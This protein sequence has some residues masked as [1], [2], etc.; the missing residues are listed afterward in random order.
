MDVIAEGVESEAQFEQL[1]KLRCKS[2]QGSFFQE[3][4]TK[5]EMGE[6]LSRGD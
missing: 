4:R 6:I 5:D 2:A 1:K 3:P